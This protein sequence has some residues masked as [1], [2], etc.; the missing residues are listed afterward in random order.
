MKIGLL[1]G[2]RNLPLLFAS[3]AKKNDL[4]IVG[5][6]F[7]GETNPEIVKLVDKSYWVDVGRLEDVVDI[8]KKENI[9][10]CVMVGQICGWRICGTRS[11][12]S[13]PAQVK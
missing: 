1:A 12:D 5:I 3:Q 6:C 7:K 13:S 2:N 4:E 9:K 8:F 11:I 10:D